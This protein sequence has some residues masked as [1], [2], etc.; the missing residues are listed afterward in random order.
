MTRRILSLFFVFVAMSAAARCAGQEFW[1][2]KDY[3][4]WTRQE[5]ERLLKN[6]PWAQNFDTVVPI[7]VTVAGTGQDSNREVSYVVQFRTAKPIRQAVVRQSLIL[8]K[9]DE[10]PPKLRAAYE[11]QGQT[12]VDAESPDVVLVH[13]MYGTNIESLDRDLAN[14]WQHQT[15]DTVRN[16]I[17]LLVPRGR[18]A[19]LAYQ[20]PTNGAREFELVFPRMLNGQP[21]FGPNDK[22]VG[23]ELIAGSTRVFVQFTVKDMIQD[24]KLLY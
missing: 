10:Q 3:R 18:I 8:A 12:F 17:A 19:P 21:L 22:S 5:C 24:G 9:S 23:F 13:V 4:Q 1:E 16:N 14:Y 2:K 11:A 7:M 20:L 15:I 6:S